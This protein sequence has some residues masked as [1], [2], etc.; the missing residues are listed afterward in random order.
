MTGR[1]DNSR[2][3][4]EPWHSCTMSKMARRPGE[5]PIMAHWGG[6]GLEQIVFLPRDQMRALVENG[7]QLDQISWEI[8]FM[9]EEGFMCLQGGTMAHFKNDPFLAI[10]Q[11]A[12]LQSLSSL[13]LSS[14]LS[15]SRLN[16][17]NLFNEI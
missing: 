15:L 1:M 3:I 7:A 9:M 4:L 14:G 16:H 17:L 10:A 2:L 8:V 13:P 12:G 5:D 11:Y 6:K